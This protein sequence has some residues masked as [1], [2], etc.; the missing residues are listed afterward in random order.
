MATTVAA[1]PWVTSCL[2]PV[3][4]VEFMACSF[5]P[6]SFETSDGWAWHELV[7]GGRNQPGA[8]LTLA[9]AIVKDAAND[10]Y[11]REDVW[12]PGV[13]RQMG[14]HFRGLLLGQ[15]VIHRPV[16]VVGNLLHLAGRNERAD[17]RQ[18]PV[19]GRQVRTQPQLPE[20]QVPGVV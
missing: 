17:G 15:P 9:G 2:S 10:R 19:S 1:P 3:Q 4:V 8:P 16:E 20:Q 6:R 5:I 14:Q 12:P 13:E 11:R 18:T 7:V